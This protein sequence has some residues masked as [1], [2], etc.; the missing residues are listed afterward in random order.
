MS[1]TKLS[2]DWESTFSTHKADNDINFCLLNFYY[3]AVS[4]SEALETSSAMI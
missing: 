3:V 2:C 4:H 1:N